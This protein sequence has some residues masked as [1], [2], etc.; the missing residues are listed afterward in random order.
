M[1]TAK[2]ILIYC[3]LLTLVFSIT[4]CSQGEKKSAN[5]NSLKVHSGEW[6]FMVNDFKISDTLNDISTSVGYGGSSSS[7]EISVEAET[8]KK[9]LLINM[10]IEKKEGTET[11]DWSNITLVDSSN[12]KYSRIHDSFLED[13]GFKRMKGTTLSFGKNE[14]W[15]AFEVNDDS[16]DFKLQY[17]SIEGIANL[18][19]KN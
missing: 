14:G 18:D 4:A 2:K 5:N 12:N 6:E 16:Q 8:G 1:K 19:L 13:F 10:V 11:I 3:L 7:N 15:I 9:F 17:E